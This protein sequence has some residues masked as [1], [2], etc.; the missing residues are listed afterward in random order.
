MR[1]HDYRCSVCGRHASYDHDAG[2]PPI[3][4]TKDC[5]GKMELEK[6]GFVCNGCGKLMHACHAGENQVP[7][8]CSNCGKGIHIGY[9][10]MRFHEIMESMIPKGKSLT[11]AEVTAVSKK[12]HEK[13]AA[14]PTERKCFPDNFTVL[15]KC[16]PE[17]LKA[18]GL[19]SDQV[20]AWTPL[21][22][23]PKVRPPQNII[24][25]SADGMAGVDAGVGE[26]KKG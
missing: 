25:G 17:E 11:P 18:Y 23:T 3:C 7:H 6:F 12:I 15:A 5:P 9:D 21:P 26:V 14:L 22:P 1:I 13:I 8:S 24:R 19:T 10:P 16:Q 4:P 2:Q 20:E